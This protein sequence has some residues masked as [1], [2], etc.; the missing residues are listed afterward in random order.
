M[1]LGKRKR[2][3]DGYK[4][5]KKV[6]PIRRRT[7]TRMSS[8]YKSPFPDTKIVTLKY[9]TIVDSDMTSGAIDTHQFSLNSCYDPD[10][11]GAGSQPL[12]WDTLM[13]SA[14]GT[15]PYSEYCV[16]SCNVDVKYVNLSTTVPISVAMVPILAGQSVP[17]AL[18]EYTAQ[19]NCVKAVVN[20]QGAA[21]SIRTLKR[22]YSIKG[23]FGFKDLADNADCRAQYDASPAKLARCVIMSQPI[24]QSSTVTGNKMDVTITYRVKLT[25]PNLVNES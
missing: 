21:N 19:S 13:G 25:R 7:R 11:S 3:N 4:P 8:P 5:R 12:Y 15:A 1:V 20:A 18:E 17:S 2:A 24:N 14:N 23:L 10:V 6:K 9:H 22:W 16:L